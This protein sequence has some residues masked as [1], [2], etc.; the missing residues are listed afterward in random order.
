MTIEGSVLRRALLVIAL[1]PGLVACSSAAGPAP[2]NGS[3][4][5]GRPTTPVSPP[6]ATAPPSGSPVTGEAPPE[7]MAKAT[8]DLVKRTGRDPATF[9]VVRAEQVI[10]PDGSLGCRI[11]GQVY[12]QVQTPGYWIVLQA[13]GKPFDY[14]ATETGVVRLCTGPQPLPPSG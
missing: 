14:R 5:G 13:N 2:S 8:A 7:V 12:V 9:V 6:F 1:A 3:P 4:S 10:W 11:P